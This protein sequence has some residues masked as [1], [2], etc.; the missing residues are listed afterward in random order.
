[1]KNHGCLSRLGPAL[2]LGAVAVFSQENYAL[3]WAS[4]KAITLNTTA[5]GADIAANQVDFPLLVRLGAD[6]ADVFAT[7]LA[8][9]AD[10]RFA[11]PDGTH[12]RYQVENWDKTNQ[13]AEIWVLVDTLLGNSSTQSLRMYWNNPQ[14]A[15]SSDGAGVFDTAN[16]F[17]GVWHLN[18]ALGDATVDGNTAVNTGTTNA[19][20]CIGSG[21]SFNGTSQYLDLG[22]SSSLNISGRITLSAWVRW[23]NGGSS[24]AQQ[25]RHIL[26]HVSP[27]SGNSETSFRLLN[28]QYHVTSYDGTDHFAGYTY[29]EADSAQ[30][31]YLV[32]AYDGTRWHLYRNAVDS[33]RADTTGALPSPG[34]WVM[35]A[36]SDASNN[37]SR[38]FS[39]MLDEVR[40]ENVT[41]SADWV[42]LCYVNQKTGQALLTLGATQTT[43]LAPAISIRRPPADFRLR[44]LQ[45]D[46]SLWSPQGSRDLRG[47]L[48]WPAFSPN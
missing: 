44:L 6:Q 20:G 33:S 48:V 3:N 15:D 16:G 5:T 19:T 32:G 37:V 26:T 13:E 28:T 43:A 18:N 31:V 10:I 38:Y 47:R 21:R 17:K 22:T 40:I 39:G 1:M 24:G 42:K 27:A 36:W 41:R 11:K 8:T 34:R 23:L 4:Y 46:P 12:L 29:T 45:A 14:A 7:A 2:L 9:G 30:W 35:G 25:H